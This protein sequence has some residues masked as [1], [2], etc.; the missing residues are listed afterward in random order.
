MI[1]I[2]ITWLTEEDFYEISN[3]IR[4]LPSQCTYYLFS[5][6][7]LFS[8]VCCQPGSNWFLSVGSSFW[9]AIKPFQR[10]SE[11][12]NP[13]LFWGI[14]L[15]ACTLALNAIGSWKGGTRG[16]AA[17]KLSNPSLKTGISALVLQQGAFGCSY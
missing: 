1:H 2:Y 6:K 12:P 10:H 4:N 17:V 15:L 7:L 5:I 16:I 8:A 14:D 13:L 3:H 9:E 11:Q